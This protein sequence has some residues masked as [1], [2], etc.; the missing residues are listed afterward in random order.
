MELDEFARHFY[1][2]LTTLSL[3]AIRSVV[4]NMRT[5]VTSVDSTFSSKEVAYISAVLAFSRL[6][7]AA[8]GSLATR[9]DGTQST[10]MNEVRMLILVVVLSV[11]VFMFISLV[12]G[13]QKVRKN[14]IWVSLLKFSAKFMNE[15]LAF[16][17]SPI[18]T[19]LIVRCVTSS[20]YMSINEPAFLFFPQNTRPQFKII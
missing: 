16:L 13:D 4:S 2:G 15:L 5:E 10:A 18:L 20:K 7:A 8:I 12:L 3:I 9:D 6:G 11:L 1:N 17:I 19:D 14:S